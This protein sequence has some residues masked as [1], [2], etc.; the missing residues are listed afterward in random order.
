MESLA[1]IEAFV[2][3]VETGSV[4]RAADRLQTAKSS[5]SDSVR[6]LEERLG[7]RLLERTTR[8]VRP[9]D[10]GRLFHARCRR[11]LDEADAARSEA[12]AF[13]TAPTGRLRLSVPETFGDRY[14][15]PGLAGFLGAFPSVKVELV[16]DVRHVRLVEEEFDLPIRMAETPAPSLVPLRIAR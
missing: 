6:A 2:L 8:H 1:G 5:V 10:A 13:Q 3:V 4:T 11:L 12:R 14:I 16:S 9:T 7:V 15:L